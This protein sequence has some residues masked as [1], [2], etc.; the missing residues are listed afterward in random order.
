[1]CSIGESFL[2]VVRS[3]RRGYNRVLGQLVPQKSAPMY[4]NRRSSSRWHQQQGKAQ[5]NSIGLHPQAGWTLPICR[6]THARASAILIAR[7]YQH[8]CME[9]ARASLP[10]RQSESI[11]SST[12]QDKIPKSR[13]ETSGQRRKRTFTSWQSPL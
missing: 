10:S 2:C 7:P 9:R 13:W 11:Y 8:I 4:T 12:R 3:N 1:M 6:K 5:T